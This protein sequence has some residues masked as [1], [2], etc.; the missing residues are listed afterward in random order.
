MRRQ[1]NQL[2]SGFALSVEFLLFILILVL[3]TISGWVAIRDSVNAELVDT[4]NAIESSITF[5]YF[6]DPN[7][8]T[9]FVRTDITADYNVPPDG[10]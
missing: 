1:S 4:A 2:Q 7:R 3:G 8:G 9:P 10:E 6:S 5:Y